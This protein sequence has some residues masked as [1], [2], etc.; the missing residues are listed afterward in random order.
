MAVYKK[1]NS[2]Y[3]YI[4]FQLNGET[5]I[6][7]SKTTNKKLADAL[8]KQWRDEIIES[9]MT[10]KREHI[11][12]EKALELFVESKKKQASRSNLPSIVRHILSHIDPKMRLFD[13]R[14]SHV[15]K[16]QLALLDKVSLLTAKHILSNL[17][18]AINVADSFGYITSPGWKFP[19]LV[20]PKGRL[21]FLSDEQE[22]KLLKELDPYA[23]RPGIP[24][25]FMNRPPLLLRQLE[26]SYAIVVALL[27]TG[28]RIGELITLTW[29]DVDFKANVIR[30]YRHKVKNESVITM[31]KRLRSVFESLGKGKEADFIFEGRKGQCRSHA[32]SAIRKA[33]KRAGLDGYHIHDLRHTFATRLIRNGATLFEVMKM[34]GHTSMETTMVY[35]HLEQISVGEKAAVI[36]NGINKTNGDNVIEFNRRAA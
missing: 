29:K 24:E 28:M 17:R 21:M 30:V 12:V 1:K 14:L 13:L 11:T 5:Y 15:S 10:G 31:T 18:A 6:K 4:Q 7:S 32:N 33:F 8:E 2:P 25:N 22:A 36:L 35:A 26:D 3:W 23:S 9:G 20:A 19:S 34:L 16:L 27:D